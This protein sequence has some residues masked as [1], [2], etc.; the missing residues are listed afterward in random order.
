V[1][2]VEALH[3]APAGRRDLLAALVRRLY[4]NVFNPRRPARR[5]CAR[6]HARACAARLAARAQGACPTTRPR[7]PRAASGLEVR[8]SISKACASRAGSARRGGCA[9]SSNSTHRYRIRIPRCC[10][11]ARSGATPPS[12]ARPSPP[13]ATESSSTIRGSCRRGRS[14]SAAQR[15]LPRSR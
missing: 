3:D 4:A 14:R 5:Q 1:S 15:R 13:R 7:R 12:G 8:G 6:R 11:V 10:A 2:L 9:Q